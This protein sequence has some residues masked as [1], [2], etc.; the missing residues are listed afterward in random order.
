MKNLKLITFL[1]LVLFFTS[2]AKKKKEEEVQ[3]PIDNT[4]VQSAPTKFSY[5]A[6]KNLVFTLGEFKS[7]QADSEGESL[8]YSV[9]N[10]LPKGLALNLQTGEISGSA[11]ELVETPKSYTVVVSNFGGSLKEEL[12]VKV[13]DKA[14]SAINYPTSTIVGFINGRLDTQI[15][16]LTGGSI[17]KCEAIPAL[18]TGINLDN[19]K[20]TISGASTVKLDPSNFEIKASNSGGSVSTFIQIAILPNPPKDLKYTYNNSV[21]EEGDNGEGVTLQVGDQDKFLYPSFS[22]DEADTFSIEPNLPRGLVFDDLT[23]TIFGT[24]LE[25]RTKA[26]YTITVQNVSGSTSF[27]FNLGV[28]SALQKVGTGVNHSCLIRDYKLYC[29]GLNDQGQLGFT[30]TDDCGGKAC[31]KSFKVVSFTDNSM[32]IKD[33]ALAKDATC[34]INLNGDTFCFG[35]NAFGKIGLDVSILSTITP[36]KVQKLEDSIVSDLTDIESLTAGEDHFIFSR[37]DGK[38]FGLGDNSGGQLHAGADLNGASYTSIALS[39]KNEQETGFLMN[40]KSFSAGKDYSCY[41]DQG[42]PKCLVGSRLAEPFFGNGEVMP[43]T[44]VVTVLEYNE[45][46]PNLPKNITNAKE[47]YAN[48]YYNYLI[49]EDG[50]LLSW[51]LNSYN[52]LF[53]ADGENKVFAKDTGK[54]NVDI[55]SLLPSSACI[56]KNV[57]NNDSGEFEKALECMGQDVLGSLGSENLN[58]TVNSSTDV[59]LLDGSLLKNISG[60][61]SGLGD[62]RCAIRNKT[63]LYCWGSNNFGQLGEDSVYRD[64]ATEITF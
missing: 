1:S 53:I 4:P 8:I 7:F 19:K 28:N 29:S 18:P 42:V 47:I 9:D 11:L 2:C 35:S 39:V 36:T 49:L 16:T 52:Q 56:G 59:T 51:G 63:S 48:E 33:F 21:I 54:I 30:S 64:V 24:P 5:G 10:H 45:E 38:D 60:V 41:I 40:S 31:S 26:L 23:G 22:G 27:S 61:S 46:N 32:L 44:K 13:I 34:A 57:L 6:E 15:P 62:H 43:V 20:C 55:V 14:P 50:R 3:A 12:T 17:T 25:T 58:Q 37:E